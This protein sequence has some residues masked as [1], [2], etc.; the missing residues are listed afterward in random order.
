MTS[1][2]AVQQISILQIFGAAC[3]LHG[4]ATVK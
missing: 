1:L 3:E 4:P 2:V